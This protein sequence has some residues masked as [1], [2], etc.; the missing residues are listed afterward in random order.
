[1]DTEI[2]VESF[3]LQV[4]N[5]PTKMA[6][7]QQADLVRPL[8]IGQRKCNEPITNFLSLS[9]TSMFKEH[10]KLPAHCLANVKSFLFSSGTGRR[11]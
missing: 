11:T 8:L 6:A 10:K 2:H 1:M 3:F 9:F 5:I 7:S 4:Q